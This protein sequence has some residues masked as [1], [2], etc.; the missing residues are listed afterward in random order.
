MSLSNINISI[1]KLAE[2]AQLGTTSVLSELRA[3]PCV[4]CLSD[5]EI[6]WFSLT[7]GPGARMF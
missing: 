6:S 2:T 3:S 1:L 7:P 5:C 4:D